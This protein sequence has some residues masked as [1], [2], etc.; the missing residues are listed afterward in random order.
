VNTARPTLTGRYDGRR[1]ADLADFAKFAVN[2]P[3]GL[4][5]RRLYFAWVFHGMAGVNTRLKLAGL[6]E[7]QEIFQFRF[8]LNSPWITEVPATGDPADNQYGLGPS[9]IVEQAAGIKDYSLSSA[10]LLS[11]GQVNHGRAGSENA[12]TFTRALTSGDAD[13]NLAYRVTCFPFNIAAE[14]DELAVTVTA[15]QAAIVATNDA[16]TFGVL[17]CWSQNTPT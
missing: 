15:P 2:V 11:C 3:A 6:R 10:A 14:I 16:S 13:S 8:W 7:S 5:F 17:G 1:F 12:L 9:W 4:P